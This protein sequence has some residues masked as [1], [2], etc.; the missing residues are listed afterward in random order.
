M[1]GGIGGAWVFWNQVD[2]QR[3][4]NGFLVY[5]EVTPRIM[6][7]GGIVAALLGIVAAIGPSVSVARMSVVSGLKTLD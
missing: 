7:T 3:L 5:F 6:A 4:T 1:E 2:L